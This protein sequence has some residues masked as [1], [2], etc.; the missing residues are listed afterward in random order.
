MPKTIF[1]TIPSF[2]KYFLRPELI[3][4]KLRWTVCGLATTSSYQAINFIASSQHQTCAAS[5]V[6]LSL[7]LLGLK[8]QGTG[9]GLLGSLSSSLS[10][11]PSTPTGRSSR[12]RRS[13]SSSPTRTWT[14]WWKI[15]AYTSTSLVGW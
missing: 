4:S 7:T 11:P 5:F 10:A 8:R 14:R 3:C 9:R 6:S 2:I 1:F 13:R 15:R 12:S